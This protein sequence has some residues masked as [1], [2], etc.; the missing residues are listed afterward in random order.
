MIFNKEQQEIIDGG[1]NHI[2]HSSKQVYQFAGKAG[3]GKTAVLHEMIRRIGIPIDRVACMAYIGQ[4]AIVMRTRG[5]WGAKTAHSWLYE[6]VMEPVLDEHGKQLR[7]QVYNTPL[8]RVTFI[9]RDLS[10]I[11]YFIIDEARTLPLSMKKDI[12]SRGKQIIACGDQ[13][14][15]PPVNDEP[16]YIRD[17]DTDIH[18]LTQI[19]RQGKGS[20]ILQIADMVSNGIPLSAGLY[21]NVLVIEKKD[22]TDEMIKYAQIVICGTNK[23]RDYYN[24]YVRENI[25][26]FHTHLPQYGEKVICRKNNW[27]MTVAGISLANGLIGTVVVPPDVHTFDGKT[28]TMGFKPDLLGAYFPDLR[29]DYRYFTADKE[30]RDFIKGSKF[31]PGE[32]FEYAYASTTHLCQGSQYNNGIYIEEY[33]SKDIQPNINYT[34]ATRFRNFLIYVIPNR[35][36]Y[37]YSSKPFPR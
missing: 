18:Y 35:R 24:N 5:L 37:Y 6:P 36:S 22:L 25:L 14:Q 12:E 2:R 32:K 20:G 1:V 15:L 10:D 4:A 19:M 28:F 11:D 13:H 9:P 23:T 7:D 26:G 31:F 21:D 29:C 34:A 3:T 30:E 33:L 27:N 16:A 17:D 8:F